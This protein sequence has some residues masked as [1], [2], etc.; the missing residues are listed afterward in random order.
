MGV[1]G[2][3]LAPTHVEVELGC[4]KRILNERRITLN[5]S[6]EF[7]AND[8]NVFKQFEEALVDVN[9]EKTIKGWIMEDKDVLN[10]RFGKQNLR[11]PYIGKLFQSWTSI[12]SNTKLLGNSWLKQGGSSG[13]ALCWSF[14]GHS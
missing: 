7:I 9:G 2:W 13:S 14:G 4:D 12:I 10:G 8:E 5:S 6:S 11:H 1:V 3:G